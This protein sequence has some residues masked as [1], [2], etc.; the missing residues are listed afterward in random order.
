MTAIDDVATGQLR[1]NVKESFRE[2]V[3]E[4][5]DG[6]EKWTAEVG[7]ITDGDLV[8]PAV[9]VSLDAETA[10]PPTFKFGGGVRF[11]GY[12]GMLRVDIKDPWI[13]VG[14]AETSLTADTAPPGVPP[15]RTVIATVPGRPAVVEGG[16]CVWHPESTALTAAGAALLGSVYQPG[17]EAAGFSFEVLPA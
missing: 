16:A 8:F 5:P 10:V 15:R 1:W 6:E 17:T 11:T 9:A 13:E 14:E 7:G 3:R 12:R 4:L 2:Y